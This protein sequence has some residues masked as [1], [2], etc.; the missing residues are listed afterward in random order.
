MALLD[1]T[2]KITYGLIVAGI[3]PSFA[4]VSANFILSKGYE[5]N[6]DRY[7]LKECSVIAHK[8]ILN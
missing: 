1:P 5:T 3:K 2:F 6:L 8:L 7:K 4:S